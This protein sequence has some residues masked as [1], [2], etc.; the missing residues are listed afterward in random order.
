MDKRTLKSRLILSGALLSI[1]VVLCIVMLAGRN[2]RHQLTCTALEV[3]FEDSLKFVT[4]DD[5]QHAIE[6]HYG[7]Y[8][9]QRLDSVGLARIE[10]VVDA[11]S[12]VL[13]SEAYTTQD[14]SLH[15][16]ITQREPVIRFQRGP[17]G[18]YADE[19][20]FI[21]PLQDNYTCDVPVIDGNIPIWHGTD[22]KGLP[23][24]DRETRWMHDVLQMMSTIQNSSLW[25]NNIGQVSVDSHGDLILIPR[26]GDERFI[27]GPPTEV[28]AKLERMARYY[29]YILP[30]KDSGFYKTVNVKYDGQIIC[31]K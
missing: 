10:Q 2:Y 19:R 18:F 26:Q 31:R 24:G 28:E 21:F 30:S 16:M 22:Y 6:T 27:F 12:A 17:D 29:E 25:C 4:K 7:S 11:Q 13:K 9:G 14:G 3:T 20:G 8:I 1:I 5:V 15:V 23:E